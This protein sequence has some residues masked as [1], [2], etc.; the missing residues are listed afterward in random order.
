MHVLRAPQGDIDLDVGTLRIW[1]AADDNGDP[2]L[3]L[4][5]LESTVIIEFGGDGAWD[6]AIRS[7]ERLSD[8]ALMYASTLRTAMGEAKQKDESN[9]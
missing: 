4:K 9:A 3:V 8:A 2:V 7:A 6:S 1:E 5:D